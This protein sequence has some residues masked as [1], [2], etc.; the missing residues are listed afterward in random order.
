LNAS[1]TKIILKHALLANDSVLLN[2]KHGIGKT[3]VVKQF[4][5]EQNMYCETLVLS[6][7]DPS[8]LLGM[9]HI[10]DSGT[11]KRTQWAEP[12]WFQRIVD[13][14]WPEYFD[15]SDLEFEDSEFED[16]VKSKHQATLN[17]SRKQLNERYCEFYKKDPRELQLTREQYNVSCKKSRNS[18]LFLDELNRALLDTRNTSLQL[19]LEKELHSHKLPFVRG[20]RTFICAAINPSDIYQTDDLDIALL[21]RFLIVNMT[22]DPED[23]LKYARNHLNE[24]ICDFISENPDKLHYMQK[25]SEN[26]STPRSW[27]QLSLHLK[28]PMENNIILEEI[29]TGK[30][31]KEVGS[32]FYVYYKNY[33]SIFKIEDIVEKVFSIKDESVSDISQELKIFTQDIETIRKHDLINQLLELSRE[34]LESEKYNILSLTLICLLS[35]FNFE[36]SL[37]FCKKLKSK[38]SNTYNKLVA[39]DNKLNNKRLFESL[40]KYSR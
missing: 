16:Y 10:D 7:K 12:D 34:E 25:D 40:I 23:W 8:D 4:A 2:G 31:G 17:F 30:L 37:A 33:S 15:Y 22:L 29:I 36:I 20:T 24:I 32:L 5:Q 11:S 14:A 18:V 1:N 28:V 19:V 9:P 35:S 3:S 39:L 21:D 13:E 6:L 26:G 27:E 38:D